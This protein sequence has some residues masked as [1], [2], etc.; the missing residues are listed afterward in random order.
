MLGQALGDPQLL[1]SRA[2]RCDVISTEVDEGDKIVV[3]WRLSGRIN[4]PFKPPIKPYVVV[5][6]FERD[7]GEV[8]HRKHCSFITFPSASLLRGF[9]QDTG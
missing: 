2:R 7:R 4:L 6:T 5:T 3:R 9:M 1:M 8:F